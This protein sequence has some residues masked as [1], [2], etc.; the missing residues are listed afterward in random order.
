MTVYKGTNNSSIFSMNNLVKKTKVI[1]I[2]GGVYSSLG[3]GT[4]ISSIGKILTNNTKR[5][6]VLKFDPYLNVNA[7]LISPSQHGEDFVT[8]DGIETDL[9]LGN[10][11]R[12]IEKE[13]TKLS[14]VT[15]GRIYKEIIDY[16]LSGGYKGKT[17]QV[18]PHVTNKIKEKIYNIINFEQP[19]FLLI[20]IGGTVGDA[21]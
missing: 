17:I 14:T 2:F 8:K 21:E 9:D 7:G 18:I 4:I 20:E 5:V 10:Y 1:F 11:E 3:K 19:D 13:L 12:F 6:S 15:S 16:E